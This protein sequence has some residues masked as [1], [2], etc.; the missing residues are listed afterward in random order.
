VSTSPRP[1]APSTIRDTRAGRTRQASAARSPDPGSVT[2]PRCQ[3]G[4][5]RRPRPRAPELSA[6]RSCPAHRPARRRR[7]EP[8]RPTPIGTPVGRTARPSPPVPGRSSRVRS[9]GLHR[10]SRSAWH[11][12]ARRPAPRRDHDWPTYAIA[13]T[14]RWSVTVRAGHELSRAGAAAAAGL[15]RARERHHFVPTCHAPSIGGRASAAAPASRLG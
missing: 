7:D 10:S 4:L 14:R 3:D 13:V 15:C 8:S 5:R 12:L 9:G 1:P 11:G 2:S 6:S